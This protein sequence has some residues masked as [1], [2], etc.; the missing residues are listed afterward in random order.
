MEQKVKVDQSSSKQDATYPGSQTGDS[1]SGLLQ[2][3]VEEKELN[4]GEPWYPCVLSWTFP[5]TGR[6]WKAGSDE[7][8]YSPEFLGLVDVDG[9][10]YD[11]YEY[12]RD[13]LEG[14]GFAADEA[15]RQLLKAPNKLK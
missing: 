4:S 14:A 2:K 10:A 5:K 13:F 15:P 3:K 11:E 6:V 1:G 8:F 7:L 9:V 12:T